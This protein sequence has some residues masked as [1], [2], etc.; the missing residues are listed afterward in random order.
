MRSLRIVFA[1]VAGSIVL[2]SPVHGSLYEFVA[3]ST[4]Y[5]VPVG[6]YVDVPVYLLEKTE[7][8]VAST[9]ANEGGLYS[10]SVLLVRTSGTASITDAFANTAEFDDIFGPVVDV[11][12]GAA[13]IYEVRN[14]SYDEYGSPIQHLD[15]LTG[16]PLSDFGVQPDENTLGSG[17][18]YIEL[19]TFRVT[20]GTLGEMTTFLISRDIV[21]GT[22]TW[23]AASGVLDSM[24]GPGDFTVTVVPLPS[25]VLLCV[26][27]MSVSGALLRR[28]GVRH[29]GAAA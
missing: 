5:Y 10:A 4:D 9:I 27:G 20:A 19:G 2:C 3:G 1:V 18:W 28:K 16:N 15:P 22:L 6:G 29:S 21:D 24:I 13:S 25:A 26:G 8:G 7:A 17:W 23:T 12:D 14:C 11:T